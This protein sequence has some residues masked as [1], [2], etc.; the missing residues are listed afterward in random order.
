MAK[1]YD[2]E[3]GTEIY[4]I[5]GAYG[6]CIVEENEQKYFFVFTP[7]KTIKSPLKRDKNYD[8]T[9]DI[10]KGIHSSRYYRE[11]LIFNDYAPGSDNSCDS[12]YT[13][14][15]NDY[16][17]YLKILKSGEIK[18]KYYPQDF[19][20]SI[21]SNPF[22]AENILEK[23]AEFITTIDTFINALKKIH[24]QNLEEDLER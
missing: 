21:A 11:W 8:T 12:Y 15:F 14:K 5:N 3:P 20:V 18:L 16:E 9:Y 23:E 10:V 7:E 6:G 4:V 2:L 13:K 24:T 19:P 1:L 17:I 22:K